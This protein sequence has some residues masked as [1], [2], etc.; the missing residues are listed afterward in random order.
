MRT[1]ETEIAG[2][3]LVVEVGEVAGQTS[4]SAMVRYGDTSILA[5]AGLSREPREGMDFFP[6]S[7][8]YEEKQYSVGKIPGGFL[9]RE[10]KPSEKA[11]LHSRLIDRPIRPLFPKGMRNDVQIITT[12]MSDD[13]D[14]A[15]EITAM[16]GSSIA[17]SISDIPFDG[18][19]ASVAVGLVDGELIINPTLAQREKSD[20]SLV[21]SGTKEAVMMVEAGANE[22]SEETML[23]AIMLAHEE[24]KKII[25]FIE[26]IQKEV[27]KEK[28]EVTLYLPREELRQ[29]VIEFVGDKLREAVHTE[30]KEER[31]EKI[32]SV[33]T[34][35]LDH[36]KDIYPEEMGD[37]K[38]VLSDIQKK[39]V[40][41]LILDDNIR[42]DNRAMTEIRP[43]SSRVG[44]LPRTHGSGLFT[45]GE[46][47][48]LSVATLGVPRDA[49]LIDGLEVDETE[50]R[51]MHHYNFPG[52]SVG[53][54]RPSRGPGRREIGHGALAERALK[55]VLPSEEEFP[56]TI[57]VVSEVLSSNGSTSQA[58]VCGS[59]LSLM[60]AG[61]PIKK[62]VAGVAMGLIKED[63]KLAILTD[64][65]GM[66]DHMGDMDFKVAGTEDGIT[67]IQMDIKIH[68]ID[69]E[70]LT[71]A[72]AQAK[73]GRL[74]ILDKMKETIAEPR[75]EL[76]PYAPRI[77]TM[78]I[79]PDKIREVIG[80]GGK[81]IN[82]IIEETG[83]KI[84]IDDDGTVFIASED[85]EKANRAKEIIENITRDIEVGE[86]FDG[87]VARITTFGAFITL[88]G[89]KEGLV[90]I[91]KLDNKHV[92]KVE[93][94]VNVGDDIKVKVIEIDNQGKINLT[95]IL[96][97]GP[98]QAEPSKSNN[99]RRPNNSRGN[100][101]FNNRNDR[102]N[103]ENRGANK[104]R[105]DNEG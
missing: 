82:G 88:P 85:M 9:R 42:P 69:R 95:R 26:E 44:Y 90:H 75:E 68:G 24:I 84:D 61:V 11:I 59:T 19:T 45:R 1:F 6:L 93:D 67:A 104:K 51:Y 58:S 60:D 10:G 83:V 46:T 99:R 73:E 91:S 15:P 14:N 4:G 48:V 80:T 72:L 21:V 81:V 32:S 5:I 3:P 103:R 49:Q 89:G 86:E 54:T 34:E 40:R 64:I 52:Y 94:V 65:Q 97:D 16:L 39:E 12:V 96:A 105:D 62:P 87:K 56:Y 43:L 31:I 7:V 17:L 22:V 33:E 36:F 92:K 57:R 8:D 102:H 79:H 41:S 30:G 70:I 63:E 37:I 27:G 55:P 101:N 53:D 47:Q 35:V 28:K 98:V 23:D 71:K 66:E 20:L 18:P 77:I 100:R 29:E 13:Q 78:S 74:F 25:E 2:R 38:T 76:S 50:K